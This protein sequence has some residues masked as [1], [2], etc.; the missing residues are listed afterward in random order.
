[1]TTSSTLKVLIIAEAANPEWTSVPLLGWSHA[2]ALAQDCDAH[3]LTQIRNKDA[4]E[5]FGWRDGVEFTAIN[6]EKYAAPFF[7]L[8]LKLRGG[9]KLGWTISTAI[10]SLCYPYFEKLC[11]KHCQQALENGEYDVVHRITPVS[12]TAPSYMAKKLKRLGIPFIIGP[13]NGGVAWPPQFRDLQHKEKEW[14]SY[15]RDAYKLLPGY[16]SLRK[17]SDCIIAGSMATK[18]QLPKKYA[19]K[20]LYLPENAID[21]QRFSLKN[22]PGLINNAPDYSLPIK[23]VFVG[24]LVPYKGADMAIEA[25]AE[26]AK[27]GRITFD[28]YGTGPEEDALKSLIS[29]LGV[30][31]QMT[32]H[33]FVPNAELQKKLVN[34]DILVFPSI[35]EFGGGVVLE[36]MAL[37]LVPV[38]ADYAGPAELVTAECGYLIPMAD[39]PALINSLQQQLLAI[40]DNPDELPAKRQAC[41]DR[42]ERFYT[43]E[44]KSAQIQ[45]IYHWLLGQADKPAFDKPFED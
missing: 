45:Q 12:P 39:R 10:G 34:A 9:D 25:M 28:I 18:E 26:L 32:V 3:L 14:L 20:I 43:W 36:S 4:I 24:R 7:K 44:K 19:D 40:C 42:I 1:M 2:Y 11:W 30:A 15:I 35:R 37:G 31:Q 29:S 8:A 22:A 21:T 6:S 23:A 38:I 33:G 41:L 27:S 13:L 5:R 17:N 16:H